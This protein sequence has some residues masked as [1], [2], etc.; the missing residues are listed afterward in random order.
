MLSVV[1][2]GSRCSPTLDG[3]TTAQRSTRITSWGR[4]WCRGWEDRTWGGEDLPVIAADAAHEAKAGG[5][6]RSWA[7]GY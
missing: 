2:C 4:R 6:G 3:P 5:G 1:L 7:V